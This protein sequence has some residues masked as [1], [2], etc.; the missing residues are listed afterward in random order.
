MT[1]PLWQDGLGLSEA[2]AYAFMGV[3]QAMN[4]LVPM[5]GGFMA[6]NIVGVRRSILIGSLLLALAYA[7][8]MLSGFFVAEVGAALFILKNLKVSAGLMD[9][10][11]V[12]QN[13][14]DLT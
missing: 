13:L 5:L 10:F 6:D 4:Y 3:S 12:K 9:H 8:V 11:L 2:E 1:R 7:L 14:R